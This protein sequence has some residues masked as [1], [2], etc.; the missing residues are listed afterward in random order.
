MYFLGILLCL[1]VTV[2]SCP[3]LA[4]QGVVSDDGDA[5]ALAV[6]LGQRNLVDLISLQVGLKPN[7]HTQ[8]SYVPVLTRTKSKQ[9]HP[10]FLSEFHASL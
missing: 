4:G 5:E 9:T 6:F 10:H 1:R 2:P 8:R 3:T 7:K